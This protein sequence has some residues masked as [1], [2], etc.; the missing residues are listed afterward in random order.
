MLMMITVMGDYVSHYLALHKQ[1]QA[2]TSDY[3]SQAASDQ[4]QQPSSQAVTGNHQQPHN[5][6]S[7]RQPRAATGNHMQPLNPSTRVPPHVT[8]N[9][10]ITTAAITTFSMQ[11]PAASPPSLAQKDRTPLRSP[12]PSTAQKRQRDKCATT[13]TSSPH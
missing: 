1:P 9:P 8:I 2:T 10:S 5:S 7:H 11:R 3:P 4:D 12:R 13:L 6:S